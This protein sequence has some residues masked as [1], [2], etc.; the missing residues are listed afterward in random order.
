MR[1]RVQ[2]NF[3]LNEWPRN[4]VGEHFEKRPGPRDLLD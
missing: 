1:A 4:Q 2:D 3:I